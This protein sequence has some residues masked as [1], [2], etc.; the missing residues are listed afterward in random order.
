VAADSRRDPAGA[1]RDPEDVT[2]AALLLA[3]ESATWLTGVTPGCGWRLRHDLS[4][5]TATRSGRT[6][7]GRM[8]GMGSA[9]PAGEAG[10]AERDRISNKERTHAELDNQTGE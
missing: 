6:V 1:A 8:S 2:L 5:H 7:Q 3:S 9:H 4:T 10:S